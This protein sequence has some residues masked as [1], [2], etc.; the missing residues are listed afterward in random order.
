MLNHFSDPFIQTLYL[1]PISKLN[2][3]SNPNTGLK[4]KGG[5]RMVLPRI[6]KI[7]ASKAN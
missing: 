1:T 7:I 4:P 6:R 5:F 2:P 3:N